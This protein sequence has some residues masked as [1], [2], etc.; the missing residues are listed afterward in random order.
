[1]LFVLYGEYV[2]GEKKT[3][4]TKMQVLRKQLEETKARQV[5]A[6]FIVYCLNITIL[7][8]EPRLE[9]TLNLNFAIQHNKGP[10][11]LASSKRQIGQV[12]DKY[13]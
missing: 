8:W 12:V 11:V 13:I 7:A 9:S 5:S 6:T 2:G 10:V 1:M 4:G 3:R